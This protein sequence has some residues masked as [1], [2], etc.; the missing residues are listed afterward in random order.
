MRGMYMRSLIQSVTLET[1]QVKQKFVI[2]SSKLQ[3]LAPIIAGWLLDMGPINRVET[4]V[5]GG[6]FLR[7]YRI[8]FPELNFISNIRESSP[9][10]PCICN[11]IDLLDTFNLHLPNRKIHTSKLGFNNGKTADKRRLVNTTHQTFW[12]YILVQMSFSTRL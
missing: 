8:L 11:G 4:W 10:V 6:S 12:S 3:N 2:V 5:T 9:I 7:A 1:S